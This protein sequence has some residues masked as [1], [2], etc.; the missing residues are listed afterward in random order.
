MVWK[1]GENV[2]TGSAIHAECEAHC[3]KPHAAPA[4]L[5]RSIL[6]SCGCGR[7]RRP[8]VYRQEICRVY[9]EEGEREKNLGDAIDRR[10]VELQMAR[11]IGPSD[12]MR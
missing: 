10:E 1:D 4:F 9:F 11:L 12:P 7:R 8:I 6:L 2:L 5:P 3:P